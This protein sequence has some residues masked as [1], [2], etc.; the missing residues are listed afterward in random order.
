MDC[1]VFSPASGKILIHDP[2]SLIIQP[3]KAH[4]GSRPGPAG[5]LFCSI[6]DGAGGQGRTAAAVFA[7]AAT[8][9]GG[10][11]VVSAVVSFEVG[12]L[13]VGLVGHGLQLLGGLFFLLRLALTA[14]GLVVALAGL[15]WW[16][17]WVGQVRDCWWRR[18]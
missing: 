5:D 12:C 11:V 17:R 15:C 13:E 16:R 8:S 18:W 10:G 1:G 7:G 9:G 14:R 4:T 2:F 6:G 3:G